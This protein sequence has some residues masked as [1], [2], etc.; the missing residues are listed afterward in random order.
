[1][2]LIK[3]SNLDGE[4]VFDVVIFPVFFPN[5]INFVI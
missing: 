2:N 3:I 4:V 1:M 5:F